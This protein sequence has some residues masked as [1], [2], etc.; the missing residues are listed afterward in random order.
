MFGKILG[1]VAVSL[2]FTLGACQNMSPAPDIGSQENQLAAAG[3]LMKPANTPERQAMLQRLPALQF[4]VRTNGDAVHYVYS[5]PELCDCLYVGTQ[6]NYDT[7]RA[8]QLAQNIATANQMAAI[9]Y[10]DSAWSW[11]A[12]GP[13]GPVETPVGF[14]YEQVGW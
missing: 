9:T 13:W 12:W 8:N 5:D 14:V 3:F 1:G 4:I 7:Y 10:A 6:Q 11:G 2:A